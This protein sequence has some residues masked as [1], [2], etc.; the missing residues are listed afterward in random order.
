MY[1]ADTPEDRVGRSPLGRQPSED[2]RRR[3]AAVLDAHAQTLCEQWADALLSIPRGLYEGSPREDVIVSAVRFFQSYLNY[4]RSGD[5]N[6]LAE[7]IRSSARRR[8]EGGA[9]L[10]SLLETVGAARVTLL[11]VLASSLS[12]PPGMLTEAVS[13]LMSAEEMTAVW[14]A[15]AYE[16][17]AEGHLHTANEGRQ[18][19][20]QEKVTFGREITR[21][22]TGERLV[23]CEAA[24]VPAHTGVPVLPVMK[25]RDVREARQIVRAHAESLGWAPSR[26]YELQLCVGEAG[27][28]AIRHAGTASFQAWTNDNEVTFRFADTGPGID[29][30]RIPSALTSGYST[31]SSLGMG[32]TLMLELADTIQLA[33]DK[34]G[35]VLQ[36]TLGRR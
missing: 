12:E 19:A 7:T 2:T 14:I 34:R 17:V 5:P 20:E 33:T 15:E 32:F 28:N 36:L 23:L 27:T 24:D 10:V 31:G 21:L 11:P 8:F 35:T 26:I 25:P 4:L 22:V 29:F 13:A 6:Q 16:S 1:S 9:A 3:M 18:R 30:N